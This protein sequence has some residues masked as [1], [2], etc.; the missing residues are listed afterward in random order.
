MVDVFSSLRS[1]FRFR[2]ALRVTLSVPVLAGL[3]VAFTSPLGAPPA[4]PAAAGPLAEDPDTTEFAGPGDWQFSDDPRSGVR[5]PSTGL[6]WSPTDGMPIFRP[7]TSQLADMPVQRPDTF[8]RSMPQYGP[9]GSDAPDGWW[10]QL[11]SWRDD[12]APGGSFLEE[13]LLAPQ[14]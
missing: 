3:L 11:P 8:K 1:P 6:T 10:Q 4:R 5:S 7:D 9:G 12:R 2:A 13:G 14:D